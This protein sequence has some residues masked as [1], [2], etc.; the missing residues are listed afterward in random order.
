MDILPLSTYRQKRKIKTSTRVLQKSY[1][2]QTDISKMYTSQIRDAITWLFGKALRVRSL[3]G[4]RT[5]N[6]NNLLLLSRYK[7]KENKKTITW[8]ASRGDQENFLSFTLD[9]LFSVNI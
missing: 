7:N 3:K 9:D 8:S 5:S 4:K 2:I 1:G 6:D